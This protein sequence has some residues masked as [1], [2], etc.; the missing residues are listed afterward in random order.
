MLESLRRRN[1]KD[2]RSGWRGGTRWEKGI[3]RGK[4]G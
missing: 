2:I 3:G 1:K 4:W